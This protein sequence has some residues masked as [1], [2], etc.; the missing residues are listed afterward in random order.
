MRNYLLA[1]MTLAATLVLAACGSD[2]GSGNTQ[3]PYGCASYVNGQCL[4][5]NGQIITPPQQLRFGVTNCSDQQRLQTGRCADAPG[6]LQVTN[7]NVYK[8]ILEKGLG[9]CSK[10]YA[11]GSADCKNLLPGKFDITVMANNNVAANQFCS[12][13]GLTVPSTIS[14]NLKAQIIQ[15]GIFYGGGSL[16]ITSTYNNG[17]TFDSAVVSVIN[18]CKGFEIRQTYGKYLLQILVKEGNLSQG[19]L[20]YQLAWGSNGTGNTP[21]VFATGT[22]YRF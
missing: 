2:G 13:K 3:Y 11:L 5:P 6:Y 16:G 10:S 22:M 14:I 19:Q 17:M 1:I 8:D 7:K 9:T 21:Y 20:N 12:D 4:G 15:N 18:D